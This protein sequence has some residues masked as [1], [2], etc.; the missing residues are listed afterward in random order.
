MQIIVRNRARCLK[1]GET[2]ESTYTHDYKTCSCGNLSVDG[3][4]DYIRRS[5]RADPDSFE[6]LSEFKGPDSRL[7]ERLEKF[8][9]KPIE[10]IERIPG[11][12]EWK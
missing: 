12:E 10:E 7:K 2:I 9:G 3:G 1:C 8:F 11:K 4:T 6:D 5:Y